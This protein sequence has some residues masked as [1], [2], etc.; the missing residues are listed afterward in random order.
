MALTC[1]KKFEIVPGATHLLGEL[2][3]LDKVAES[4]RDWFLKYMEVSE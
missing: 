1:E 3:T 4:S 2:G